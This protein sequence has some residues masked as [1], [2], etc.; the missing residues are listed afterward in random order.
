MKIAVLTS[1]GDSSGMNA[2]LSNLYDCA[3][4]HGIE[5]VGIKYGYKGLLEEN[6]IELNKNE[7]D[8]AFNHGGSLIKTARCP[9][10]MQKE[11]V[12]RAVKILNK[13]KIDCLV[14]IGGNGSLTGAC[15]LYL[16]G[17]NVIGIPGTIDNDLGY[18]SYTLGFDT[19]VLNAVDAIE[20]IS[21]TIKSCDRGLIVETMGRHCADIA[22][23]SAICTKADL[24]IV[25]KDEMK[26]YVKEIKNI[27]DTKNKSP[28]VIVQE[29]II[30]INELKENVEKTT[31]VEFRACQL[32]YVQRGGDPSPKDKIRAMQ[33]AVRAIQLIQ[34]R[35]FNKAIGSQNGDVIDMNIETAIKIPNV[36]DINLLKL[37]RNK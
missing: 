36:S 20:K 26:D 3:T 12:E 28:L 6:F 17:A 18:T 2:C 9:E 10:F 22:I 15:E 5:I 1:G 35:K 21:Q 19:A 37:I 32:G 27:I 34:E 4:S 24:L 14:V 16:S 11:A 7:L 13:H 8:V 23:Y 33:F 30:D 25:K 29:N 31:N